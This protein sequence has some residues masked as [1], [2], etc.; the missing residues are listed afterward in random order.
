MFPETGPAN[1]LRLRQLADAHLHAVERSSRGVAYNG[2][3]PVAGVLPAER[4]TA[5][6]RL[7]DGEVQADAVAAWLM[8]A[9]GAVPITAAGPHGG[10]EP[11]AYVVEFAH[12]GEVFAPGAG[13]WQS[14]ADWLASMAPRRPAPALF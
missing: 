11:N 12:K 5:L 13:S 4:G 7:A 14:R 3:S 2:A 10:G 8:S 9:T 6:L 1:G